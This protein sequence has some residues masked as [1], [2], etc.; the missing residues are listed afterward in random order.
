[1]AITPFKYNKKT[2]SVKDEVIVVPPY[3]IAAASSF[4]KHD[5]LD[6]TD[7]CMRLD[8]APMITAGTPALPT[9]SNR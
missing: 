1:M 8:T 9:T 2:S 7:T 4:K 3:L 5:P 6:N